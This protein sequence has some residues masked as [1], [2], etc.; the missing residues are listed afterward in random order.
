MTEYSF[1]KDASIHASQS[2]R[3]L[4]LHSPA[5]GRTDI[6]RL[7]VIIPLHEACVCKMDDSGDLGQWLHKKYLLRSPHHLEQDAGEQLRR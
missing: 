1:R 3:K 4:R 6:M 2:L 7:F 5:M